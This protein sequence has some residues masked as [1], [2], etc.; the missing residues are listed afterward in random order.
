[1]YQV[2][3]TKL[4]FRTGQVDMIIG[5]LLKRT[6][7]KISCCLLGR[8]YHDFWLQNNDCVRLGC[9]RIQET[10]PFMAYYVCK[11]ALEVTKLGF[12]WRSLGGELPIFSHVYFI[13]FYFKNT[14]M[15][16]SWG[17]LGISLTDSFSSLTVVRGE[18]TRKEFVT[19]LQRHRAAVVIQKQIKGQ[20]A[21]K[22]FVNI[23][24][25]SITI[26][27]GKLAF[28]SRKQSYIL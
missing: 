3:Y 10:V 7:A 26:Q 14:W 8:P 20:I 21:W 17:A 18:K 23:H 11:A 28:P 13:S 9:L 19:L 5:D 24:D 4:F 27:S 6:I 1:M 15:V 25:A 22:K 12:I 2:G 16:V